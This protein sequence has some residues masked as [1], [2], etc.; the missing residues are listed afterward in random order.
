MGSNRQGQ[1]GAGKTYKQENLKSIRKIMSRAMISI[2]DTQNK[3]Y[4][5]SF[6]HP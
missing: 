2:I 3:R 4:L 6:L 5:L 1:V